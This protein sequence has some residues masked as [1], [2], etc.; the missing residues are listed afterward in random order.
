M[1]T[2]KKTAKGA[3]PFAFGLSLL[4]HATVFFLVFCLW[5]PLESEPQTYYEVELAAGTTI[6]EIQPDDTL[7]PP[8]DGSA[9]Q[10]IPDRGAVFDQSAPAPSNMEE[11]P[12]SRETTGNLELEKPPLIVSPAE[13]NEKQARGNAGLSLVPPRVKE[14]PGRIADGSGLK[15]VV[16]LM[17]EILADGRVGRIVVSRSSGLP[18]LDAAAATQVSRWRFEPARLPADGKA[19]RV[20]TSVWVRYE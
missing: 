8:P 5:I 12:L 9:P 20:L 16:L 1:I 19:V 11:S 14:K 4:I 2:D 15:G 7:I 6:R 3:W 18:S 10:G 17:V 13:D